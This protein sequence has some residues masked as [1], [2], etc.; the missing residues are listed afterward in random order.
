MTSPADLD[1]MNAFLAEPRNAMVAG[2]R[3]DGRPQMT[4]NWF[5]WD[6]EH[7]RISTTT[8]RAKYK[9]FSRDQRV[10]LAIDDAT[11]FS[12]VLV[13]GTVEI[14][15]DIEAGL[16]YFRALREKHGS[17]SQTDA[18]LRAEMERDGR[19]LLVVTPDRPQSQWLARGF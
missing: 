9:V 2:I 16:P 14:S 15:E 13:D 7:F 5:L 12:Y 1:S 17:P 18:E 6:G 10:Q 19:V 11:G 8:D 3:R 4:P